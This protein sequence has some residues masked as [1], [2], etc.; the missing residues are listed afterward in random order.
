MPS[1]IQPIKPIFVCKGNCLTCKDKK[2][3]DF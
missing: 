1:T 3:Y 2:C